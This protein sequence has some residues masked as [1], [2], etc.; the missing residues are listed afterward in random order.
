MKNIILLFAFCIGIINYTTAQDVTIGNTTLT[1]TNL[2]TGIQIPWEILWGADDHI[3]ITER[4][5]RVLRVDPNNGNTETI[6]NIQSQVESGGEPGM[7]G[8]VLHPDFETT[9]T[10][11]LA[12]TYAEGFNVKIR[13]ASFDWNGTAL[14]NETTMIEN[15]IGGGIHCGTRLLV[16]PDNTIMITTGDGG[17]S[18]ISQN[19]NSMSGKTLRMNLDGSIPADNPD[20]NSY[21]WSSGHRNAQGLCNGPNGIVYSSE[22]GAQAS[23][24]FNIIEKGRNYGWPTVQGMC[25]TT[26]EM[27]FCNA[28]NVREP[29][30]EYTPCVAVNGI[31]YYNHPAIP[32]LQNSV[33]MAVLGG[34]SGGA[35]RMEQLKMSD[36]GLSVVEQNEFMSNLGRLRDICVNPYDG[37]IYLATNGPQ[38]PGSGPNRI[39]QYTNE[40]YVIIDNTT[41]VENNQ[42]VK[43]FPNP[44]KETGTFTFSEN[45]I[46]AEYEV[47]SFG[48]ETVM[49]KTI[50]KTTEEISTSKLAAGMYYVKA[51]N[52]VGII[53]RTFVVQ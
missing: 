46:G 4:R 52:E 37:S 32:E 5:G 7:L 16:L 29:L 28:N 47:I 9:P 2:V 18:S 13:I 19:M 44:M 20:P 41:T 10:V 42:F 22:H 25:N 1:Q 23:D 6:L 49:K 12:Y 8:M 34:L 30:T 27:N 38:Y 15:I 53:T 45:F 43:V 26:T 51:E 31:E 33:L 14:V 21:I 50:T 39:V 40:D 48:G 36:D 24:E 35:E 11:Y 17:D 3:W